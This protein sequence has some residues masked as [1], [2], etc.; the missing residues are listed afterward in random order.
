VHCRLLRPVATL[1]A[2]LTLVQGCSSWRREPAGIRAVAAANPR[3]LRIRTRDGRRIELYGPRIMNDTLTGLNGAD[4]NH[5][6][7]IPLDDILGVETSHFNAV[8]TVA[9]LAGTTAVVAVVVSLVRDAIKPTGGGAGGGLGSGG[10]GG[11]GG[12]GG[13]GG[14][15]GFGGQFSCPTV[16]SWDGTR[17]R[18]DSG[19]FGG[20]ITEGL[21]RTDVDNLEFATPQD[22]ILH[23]RLTNELPETDH[24]DALAVIAVDHDSGTVVVPDPA[25]RLHTLRDVRSPV[26]A[27][28]FA[29]RDALARI[30]ATDGR[31]WESRLT[32]RDTSRAAELRDGLELTFVRPAR[33]DTRSAPAAHLLVDGNSTTWAAELL[34]RFVTAHGDQTRAWYAALDASPGL[35]RA[36]GARLA[37]EGF[38]SASVWNGTHWT[39][40]GLFW[41]AGPEVSKQQVLE[42]DLAGIP[43]DTVRV[44]LTSAP[45][46]W[47]LDRVAMDFSVD[48][49]VIEHRLTMTRAATRGATASDVAQLIGIEDHSYY[50]LET[51]DMAE[52][53]FALPPAAPSGMVRGFILRTSGWYRIQS[54]ETGPADAGLFRA[55]A[56]DP[57][58]LSRAAV[59]RFNER[60]AIVGV[61]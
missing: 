43:G 48:T 46:F 49:P 13:G 9:M 42:L 3:A 27:A 51:G 29:G 18:I 11:S 52:L 26:A 15:G 54:D 39:E 34:G 59:A 37:R 35:A 22:G 6:A 5:E 45:S 57:L 23:L 44:R 20:A 61:R 7:R 19:T 47:R 16:Y 4:R 40:Q 12:G 50:S 30:S 38:L 55:I 53:S 36:T 32:I 24:V 58:G 10:S 25:G 21:Q 17:W 31:A 8:G 28:D 33:A 41:E 2:A 56:S 1:C 14:I 60:L